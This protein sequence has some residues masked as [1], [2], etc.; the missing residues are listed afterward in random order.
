MTG[1]WSPLKNKVHKILELAPDWIPKYLSNGQRGYSLMKLSGSK[2]QSKVTLSTKKKTWKQ[3]IVA[4]L[5]W[6]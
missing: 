5:V 6:E 1:I 2:G 4:T 3:M